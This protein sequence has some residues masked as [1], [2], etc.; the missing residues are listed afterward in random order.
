MSFNAKVY[1]P[2]ADTLVVASGG[3]IVVESGGAV[4]GLVTA[5][6]EYTDTKARNAMK[7]KAQIAALVSPPADYTDLAAATAAVKAIVDALKA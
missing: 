3:K 7:S 2:D 1:Q 5:A 4:E 6:T